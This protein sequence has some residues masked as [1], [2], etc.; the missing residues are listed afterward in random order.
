MASRHQVTCVTKADRYNPHK[1]ITHIGGRNSQGIPWQL[2]QLE[3]IAGIERGEWAFYVSRDG[4]EVAIVVATGRSGHK[5][6][7]T[8][9]DGD[10]PDGLLALPDCG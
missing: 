8:E 2:S 6:L 4:R 1:R 5:Y 7:K 9:A 3:A 10:Y